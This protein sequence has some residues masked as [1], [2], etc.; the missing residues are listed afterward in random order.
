MTE[1]NK[2]LPIPSEDVIVRG[3][4]ETAWDSD[5]NWHNEPHHLDEDQD[6]DD[7]PPEPPEPPDPPDPPHDPNDGPGPFTIILALLLALCLAICP[8][9]R[10]PASPE[11]PPAPQPKDPPAP[12]DPPQ[13]P[14]P[15]P[16]PPE[17]PPTPQ[18]PAPN[19][20]PQPPP[21][22]APEPPT[23]EPPGRCWVAREVYGYNNPSWLLFR[24]YIDYSAPK[25]FKDFYISYGRKIAGFIKNKPFLKKLIKLWMDTKI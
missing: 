3:S 24:N 25:Y 18:P 1:D 11:P 16:K 23:P 7:E 2:D 8:R 22:P 5:K 17:P 19:P 6:F 9:P 14:G 21:T 12:S 15:P 4:W 20:A 13:P 10:S